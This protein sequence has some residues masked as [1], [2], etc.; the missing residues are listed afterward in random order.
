MRPCAACLQCDALLEHEM[1]VTLRGL[2]RGV[3]SNDASVLESRT[4]WSGQ[5]LH[6]ATQSCPR[7]LDLEAILLA[8]REEGWRRGIVE[9]II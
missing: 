7:G 5:A 1:D 2:I 8:L 9:T 6:R 3:L 4:L